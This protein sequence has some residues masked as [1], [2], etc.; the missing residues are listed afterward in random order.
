IQAGR[1]RQDIGHLRGRSD[2]LRKS[3]FSHD[4]T[5]NE[6]YVEWVVE[7]KPGKRITITVTGQRTGKQTARIKL[8]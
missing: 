2:Q 1:K 5:D 6:R 7:G 8:P 4:S 3:F